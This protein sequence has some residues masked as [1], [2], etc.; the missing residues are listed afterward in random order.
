MSL[1][2]REGTAEA[3]MEKAE[4][5]NARLQ[6]SC[7][8]YPVP[9]TKF[10]GACEAN[11]FC[12][13]PTNRTHTNSA[14]RY[15]KDFILRSADANRFCHDAVWFRPS[16]CHLPQRFQASVDRSKNQA[17]HWIFTHQFPDSGSRLQP[18]L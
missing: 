8:C 7:I 3:A 13:D 12:D 18:D 17:N 5:N 11:Q 14:K 15:L 16:V 4:E 10:A 9:E 1:G 6:D 2:V